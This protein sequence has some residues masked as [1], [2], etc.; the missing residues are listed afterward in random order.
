MTSLRTMK[1]LTVGALAML[2]TMTLPGLS[3]AVFTSSSSSTATVR[4]AADWAPPTVSLVNLLQEVSGT[5]TLEAEA[6]DE[7]GS[8]V[9]SVTFQTRPVGGAWASVCTDL[10]APYQCSWDT[11]GLADGDYEVRA[12]AEDRAGFSATSAVSTVRVR[13]AAV[14]R[15]PPSVRMDHPGQI[16]TRYVD[17]RALASDV[18]SGVRSV[19]FEHSAGSD[20]PWA[21]LCTAALTPGTVDTWS[22]RYDTS[23]LPNGSIVLRATATDAAGNTGYSDLISTQV[24][25]NRTAG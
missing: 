14:D 15:I 12:R 4:A 1:A 7:F 9:A 5:Q 24:T 13:N 23:P 22:C 8:G 2:L 17:F 19:T 18:G 6:A 16:R 21:R 3:T 11:S 25:G 20:G 10:T